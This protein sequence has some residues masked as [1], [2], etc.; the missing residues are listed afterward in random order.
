[1]IA[2]AGLV[3]AAACDKKTDDPAKPDI[4]G[5]TNRQIFQMQPWHFNY[6][7]DSA[8]NDTKWDDQMDACMKDDVFN[9]YSNTKYKVTENGNKCYPADYDADWSM[10]SDNATTVTLLGFNNW[11][12]KYKSNEKLILWRIQNGTE[13]HFQQL[14]LTRD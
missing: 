5:K 4:T 14:I 1:M 11:E 7:S 12:I 9:F 10:T 3:L 8:E 6:W 13:Q 2:A